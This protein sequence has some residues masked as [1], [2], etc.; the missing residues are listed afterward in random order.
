MDGCKK[1]QKVALPLKVARAQLGQYRTVRIQRDLLLNMTER[2]FL[3]TFMYFYRT[4]SGCKA[5]SI[6]AHRNLR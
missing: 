6:P 1:L 4:L 2:S 5:L 3:F